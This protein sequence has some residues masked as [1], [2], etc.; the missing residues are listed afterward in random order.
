MNGRL[1]EK[2]GKMVL[3]KKP[4]RNGSNGN[5]KPPHKKGA[6]AA[7]EPRDD[8]NREEQNGNQLPFSRPEVSNGE[9][10]PLD[11][12]VQVEDLVRLTDEQLI[13]I[14]NGHHGLFVGTLRKAVVEH[15]RLVG[16]ALIQLKSR[17]KHGKWFGWLKKH[18]K[19]SAES[20]RLYMRIAK[21]WNLI[22][23]HGLDRNGIMLEEL[24]WVLSESP[25]KRPGTEDDAESD[26]DEKTEDE[27][28]TTEQPPQIIP[29]KEDADELPEL[30]NLLNRVGDRFGTIDWDK[31]E[32]Y[33]P[34]IKAALRH[35][36]TCEG[37]KHV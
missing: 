12:V 25:G 4:H 16:A 13:T 21:N 28:I 17:L 20:A 31:G 33:S 10:P 9:D 26:D 32:D 2:A 35:C 24:Q 30:L 1:N 19:G 11:P 18:F 22:V 3:G 29:V 37:V 14:A 23:E 5:G 6:S 8:Q 15:A 7:G 27:T 36:D 34:T